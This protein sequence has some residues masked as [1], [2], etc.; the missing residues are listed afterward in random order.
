[1]GLCATLNSYEQNELSG[2]LKQCL[3]YDVIVSLFTTEKNR[4]F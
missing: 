1:M 2:G 3:V 4:K